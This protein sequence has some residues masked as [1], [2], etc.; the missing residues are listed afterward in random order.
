M[1]TKAHTKNQLPLLIAMI[2]PVFTGYGGNLVNIITV[3]EIVIAVY[4]INDDTFFLMTPI[5][6]IYYSQLL[7]IG[8]SVGGFNLF[9]WLC[10]FKLCRQRYVS[11]KEIRP[12]AGMVV[13][14]LYASFVALLWQG[15]W[16]GINTAILSVGITSIAVK[17]RRS[18][19]LKHRFQMVMI[20]MCLSATLYGVLFVNIKGIYEQTN[21]LVYYTGRYCGTTADP[22]YMAF[23]YCVSVVYVMFSQRI[24]SLIK[25]ILVAALFF[26]T[27]ITGSLTALLA[28]FA[29]FVLYMLWGEKGNLKK[30]VIAIVLMLSAGVFLYF[31]LFTDT[32]EIAY[33]AVFKAR[34]AE[35]MSFLQS[36]NL[37]ATTSGRTEYS[38][39]YVHYLFEQNLLRMLL[40]G[41]Q[42]NAVGLAGEAYEQI[43]FA[44]HN[45]YID[46]LMTCGIV[47]LCIFIYRILSGIY[48]GYLLWHCRN[49]TQGLADAILLIIM[50]VF[51]AGLS[52]FPSTSYMLFFML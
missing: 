45:T 12:I 35:K 20:A 43:R 16:N 28:I 38:G 22:N 27:A 30:R 4:Y 32:F 7:L 52:C 42:L 29:T 33:L 41:Y 11:V 31:A 39:E 3:I 40:G 9:M 36:G 15:L 49:D 37:S 44:A 48:S 1:I 14:L 2:L 23:F 13:L 26:A 8:E 19:E 25:Y 5:F 18:T 17:I 50:A 34:I 21:G 10:C 46:V 6:I 47:G 24:S 51:I